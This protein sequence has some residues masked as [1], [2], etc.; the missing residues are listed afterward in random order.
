MCKQLEEDSASVPAWNLVLFC[1]SVNCFLFGVTV[2]VVVH[3]PADCVTQQFLRYLMLVFGFMGMCFY[4]YALI[5]PE[6]VKRPSTINDK[7]DEGGG[8]G[9]KKETKN[10]MIHLYKNTN[11]DTH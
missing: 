10:V 1:C 8:D 11:T 9:G 7:N 4:V 3:I 5:F 2:S 6:H